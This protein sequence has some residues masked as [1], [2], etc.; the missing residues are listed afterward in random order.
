MSPKD[1][2]LDALG[3]LSML[4][5]YVCEF[6]RILNHFMGVYI[7]SLWICGFNYWCSEVAGTISLH[8]DFQHNIFALRP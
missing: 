1:H 8:K 3:Q 2:G 6:M 7:V 4:W 5:K